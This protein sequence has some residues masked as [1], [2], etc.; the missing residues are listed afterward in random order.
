MKEQI[1]NSLNSEQRDLFNEFIRDYI[2]LE[3]KKQKLNYIEKN[4]NA[5][6]AD[7]F[8][9]K[10]N[11]LLKKAM[12]NYGF[13]EDWIYKET[14]IGA[15]YKVIGEVKEYFSNF[16]RAQKTYTLDKIK[17]REQVIQYDMSE[18]RKMFEIQMRLTCP[19]Y[20][21]KTIITKDGLEYKDVKTNLLFTGFKMFG[22]EM[23]M[24]INPLTGELYKWKKK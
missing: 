3:I 20:C 8:F 14:V 2:L 9:L 7:S 12:D 11:N 5:E 13:H 22:I 1:F 10:E 16:K 24:R 19:D 17:N 15:Q 23:K 4:M 6:N 18:I 21:L